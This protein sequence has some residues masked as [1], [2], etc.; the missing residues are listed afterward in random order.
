MV[1]R[2]SSP[3]PPLY[4]SGPGPVDPAKPLAMQMCSNVNTLITSLQTADL[5]KL[6]TT[7]E[8]LH[9]LSEEALKC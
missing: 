3:P 8:D 2:I 9:R 4:S 5:E 7:I 1:D 6:A